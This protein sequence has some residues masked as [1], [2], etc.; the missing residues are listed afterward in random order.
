MGICRYQ[1]WGD[2]L[3]GDIPPRDQ[4]ARTRKVEGL[5]ILINAYIRYLTELSHMRTRAGKAVC[6]IGGSHIHVP[7]EQRCKSQVSIYTCSDNSATVHFSLGYIL[8]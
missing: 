6:K 8:M 1:S 3:K 7:H 4:E 5:W 2:R